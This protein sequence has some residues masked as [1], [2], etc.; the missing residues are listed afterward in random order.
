M[1]QKLVSISDSVKEKYKGVKFGFLFVENIKVC[2]DTDTFSVL[3]RK[4]EKEIKDN[5]CSRYL[6][7]KNIKGWLKQF[8]EMGL[9]PNQISPAQIVMIKRICNGKNIPNI[10]VIVDLANIMAV[11]SKLPVGAFDLEKIIGQITLRTSKTAEKYL[12]LF[13]DKEELVPENEIVYADEDK[14]FSRYSKDCDLTKITPQTNKVFFVIDGTKDNSRE[15]IMEYLNRLESI[16]I[17]NLNG[18]ITRKE[19]IE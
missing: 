13:E 4:V 8:K 9:N 12:P 19:V 15:E 14:I 18:D 7:D 1:N 6:E 11:S 10:N 16:I 3:R 17:E 2:K 5:I